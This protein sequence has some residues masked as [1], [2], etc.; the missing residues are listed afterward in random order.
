MM[1]CVTT[2]E[3]LDGTQTGRS[4]LRVSAVLACANLVALFF[5]LLM[6]IDYAERQASDQGSVPQDIWYPFA[7]FTWG[8]ALVNGAALAAWPRSRQVG[9]GILLGAGIAVA[10]L[11]FLVAVSLNAMGS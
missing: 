3:D 2:S 11:V 8:L 6:A 4:V 9:K 7:L 5:G 1:I 10:L